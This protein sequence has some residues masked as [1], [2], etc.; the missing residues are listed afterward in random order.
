MSNYEKTRIYKV[1][2]TEEKILI[3]LPEETII[4]KCNRQNRK[5]E[6]KCFTHP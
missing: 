5:R 3:S 1:I 6:Q 2:E 4:Q